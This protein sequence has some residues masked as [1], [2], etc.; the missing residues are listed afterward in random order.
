MRSLLL[1]IAVGALVAL[2]ACCTDKCAENNE[3]K[4]DM[5]LQLYSIREL[6]GDSAKFAENGAAVLDSLAKLGYTEV[7][8]ANYNNGK[9]YGMEPEAFK[10]V[11]ENAGLKAVSTHTTYRLS[12]EE[13]AKADFTEA[14]KWW[15]QC[16][17][18][19]KAAGMEYIVAPS[20]P[21]PATVKDLDVWCDYYNQVGKKCADAGMK[22]GYHNHSFEI[23]KIEDQVVFYDYMIEHTDSAYVFFEMDVYWACMGKA[24]PVEYFKKYPGRFRLLHIKDHYEIGQSGMVGFDAIFNNAETAGLEHLVVELEG[25]TSGDIMKGVGECAE[26]LKNAPFVKATYSK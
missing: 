10:A 22:F 6:I 16:I 9:I 2:T 1:N 24:Y 20:M 3:A 11:V 13:V 25:T 26:Y 23:T 5:G 18:A 8:T 12:D 17:A 4:K 7:E 14:M 15:D 21:T 19:H